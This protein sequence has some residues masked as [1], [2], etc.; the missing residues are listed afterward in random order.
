VE[1]A[2]RDGS[3]AWATFTSCD[4]L[5]EANLL[6]S[7]AVTTEDSRVDPCWLG[8]ILDFGSAK[9]IAQLRVSSERDHPRKAAEQV[10]MITHQNSKQNATIRT[11][12]ASQS[13]REHSYRTFSAAC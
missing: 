1:I 10:A 3:L 13:R 6:M 7:K 12:I 2:I 11:H 4:K 5:F 8:D 9:R